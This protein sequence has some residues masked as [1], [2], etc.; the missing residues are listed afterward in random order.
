ME[1]TNKI[2]KM[3]NNNKTI[4]CKI[5]AKYKKSTYSN[6]Y[7]T[8][9]ICDKNVVLVITY[10]WRWGEFDITI[11]ES[12]I[13]HLHNEEGSVVINDYNGELIE[14]SDCVERF[15]EIENKEDFTDDELDEINETIYEDIEDE[16]LL[17]ESELE[18]N[19]WD[20]DNTIYEVYGDYELEFYD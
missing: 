4:T 1:N 14:L 19:G 13:E 6:E 7:W 16:I 18:E 10:V 15:F 17:D 8:N 9:R 3:N 5:N 11:L 12:E 20:I 2:T